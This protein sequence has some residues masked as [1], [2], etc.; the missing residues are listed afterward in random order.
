MKID[1]SVIPHYL[2]LR[3]G[4]P[5][6]VLNA[7]RQVLRRQASRLLL[8]FARTRGA[9]AHVDGIAWNVFS[10]S[11]GLTIVERRE[12]GFFSLVAGNE[13][14]RQLHLLTTL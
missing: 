10:D 13:T 11:E 9:I 3:A 4:C 6:Y 2:V 8:A 7:D 5:P 1:P 14:E 12:T